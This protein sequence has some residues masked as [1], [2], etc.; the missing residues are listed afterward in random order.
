MCMLFLW[1]TKREIEMERKKGS[2]THVGKLTPSRQSPWQDTRGRARPAFPTLNQE[3]SKGVN[4]RVERAVNRVA[5][6]GRRQT[7]FLQE[8]QGLQWQQQQA[9]VSK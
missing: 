8:N 7:C 5:G 9:G 4:V 1:Q 3:Q 2:Q 6:S